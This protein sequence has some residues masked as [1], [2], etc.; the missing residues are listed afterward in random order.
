MADELH[1]EQK[2]LRM[3]VTGISEQVVSPEGTA[4]QRPSRV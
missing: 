1:K 3:D 4:S 2:M